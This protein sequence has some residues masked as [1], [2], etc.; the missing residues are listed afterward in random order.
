MLPQIP[1]R[2]AGVFAKRRYGHLRSAQAGV[3]RPQQ[4]RRRVGTRLLLDK[5]GQLFGG[6]DMGH[7]APPYRRRP[8]RGAALPGRH[9]LDLCL[10]SSLVIGDSRLAG[11]QGL[12]KGENLVDTAE[13]ASGISKRRLALCAPVGAHQDEVIAVPRDGDIEL[14]DVLFLLVRLFEHLGDS[15]GCR[16]GR[17]V[18][19]VGLRFII[20]VIAE[21]CGA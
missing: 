6:R 4:G 5:P 2:A 14:A 3:Q 15:E 10:E 1:H 19:F 18:L 20:V 11:L 9:E 12:A 21:V 17:V 8:S 7:Q 16:L 13:K